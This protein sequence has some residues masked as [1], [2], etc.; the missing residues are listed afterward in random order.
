MYNKVV[1]TGDALKKNDFTL[2]LDITEMTVI[3]RA[4][5]KTSAECRSESNVEDD[6]CKTN[7]PVSGNADK[8]DG[9]IQRLERY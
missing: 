6:G 5:V 4:E 8:R 2:V 3:T 9:K 1:Y 7:K